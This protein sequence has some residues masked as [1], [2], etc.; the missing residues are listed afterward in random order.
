MTC[1]SFSFSGQIL[2]RGFWIYVWEITGPDGAKHHYVGRTGDSSSLFAAS[3][4][5]RVGRHLDSRENAKSNSLHKCLTKAGL[6]PKACAFAMHAVGPLFPEQ[7]DPEEHRR[8]RDVLACI[9]AELADRLRSTVLGTHQRPRCCDDEL[10][11]PTLAI[12]LREL[13]AHVAF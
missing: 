13:A 4:F 2:R 9:E 10:L 5:V 12:V 1:A 3:P 7:T 6:D 11:Q 8:H